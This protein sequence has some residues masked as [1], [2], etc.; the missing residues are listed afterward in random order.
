[1]AG[2]R[3]M[4]SALIG[5]YF[6]VVVANAVIAIALI[7]HAW[8]RIISKKKPKDEDPKAKLATA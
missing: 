7:M 2:N 4:G 5:E 3:L 8:K 1:M 6:R